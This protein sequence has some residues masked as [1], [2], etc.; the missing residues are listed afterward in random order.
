M[1]RKIV[2]IVIDGAVGSFDKRY[3]YTVPASLENAALPGCRVTFPFGRG[4][5]K[6]QGL[7]MATRY[8]E[9]PKKFKDIF[10][11]TDDEPILN[12]EM[13]QLCE[14][15]KEHTFCTYF[16]AVHTM[17]PTGLNHRLA[18][19][20]TVNEEFVCESILNEDEAAVF[21]LLKKEGETGISKLE[22]S[23]ENAKDIIASLEEK[24]AV[25]RNSL[26]VRRMGDATRK[27][28]RLACSEEELAEIKLTPRQREIA[29]LVVETGSIS[30][31]EVQYFTGVTLSVINSLCSKGVLE[32]FEKEVF[33]TPYRLKKVENR[34]EINLTQEQ[35][36][37]FDGLYSKLC[38]DTPFV[39]LLYGVTGS[40][41]TQVFLRLVDE[42]VDKGSGVIVMVPEIALTP[43]MIGIFSN[44]YGDKIAV[45]HSA[46]S[47][48]QRMDEYKRIKQGKALIAIG[49]RSAVF[50]PFE[51]LGLVIIDEEQEHTYK[52]EKSPRFHARDVA[53][54]RVARHNALLCLASAT[55]SV[56]T[57]SAALSGKY[58]L[59][60]MQKRYGNS[61]LPTVTVVDMKKEL[62]S[63]NTGSISRELYEAVEEALNCGKQAIVLLNRRGHNTYITCPSCGYVA[64]C[65]NC[66]VSMTYHSANK[67]MMCHY[68][69]YSESE[70]KQC[71][72]CGNENIR[73]LGVGTQKVE[74]ELKVLF[75]KA[76]VLRMDADNTMTRDSYSNNLTAF[77]SGEYDIMLGTQMVA[78]GLDFPNVTL[79]GVI[80]ADQAMFSED[81]RSFERTFSLLTQVVGRAGRG[82][83]KGRAVIQSIDPESNV[84]ALASVQD[85]DAFYRQEIMTRKVMTFPPYCDICVICVQSIDRSLAQ[86]TIRE[87]FDK[88]KENL[89]GEYNDV[90]MIILGPTTAAM[91]KVNNRYRY[92]MTVKC[93]NNKRFRELLRKATDIRLK[94]DASVT[95]DIN[96][97]SVI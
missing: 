11:V 78:K 65:P 27:G 48:G 13:L 32:M 79:V 56:E 76:R 52:S 25:L 14:W 29:N 54:F 94:R 3:S 43:Q 18:D 88:I 40:G 83:E 62:A 1:C 21:S 36:A 71:P 80:G 9:A 82:G 92:R 45:F 89:D 47:L 20:Y 74:E 67:R 59:Y 42:T 51:N 10:E 72:Q 95:M 96:P 93:K 34:P 64:S 81:Y 7:I 66:S 17:L 61:V 84:I 22:K 2:D 63:G 68:C 77:A 57:Y 46:M 30:V 38:A 97:E 60:T 8:G 87:I 15:M 33:R 5:S 35:Q 12:E 28:V 39:S 55:P 49:T 41:K 44:R 85:Y 31:K 75:P 16:D 73:F 6:R 26:S 58:A 70:S 24:Q 4:D 91:P 86:D 37:A 69:G 23:F 53:K 19:Y 50:A 90:K